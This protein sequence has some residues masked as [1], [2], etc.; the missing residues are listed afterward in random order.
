VWSTES[1]REPFVD[2]SLALLV[3]FGEDH[4]FD[5]QVLVDRHFVVG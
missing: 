5:L 2:L 1:S 3:R 4:G